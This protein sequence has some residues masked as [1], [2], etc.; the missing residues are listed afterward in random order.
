VAREVHIH[1]YIYLSHW[2]YDILAYIWT[3]NEIRQT[4]TV[5]AYKCCSYCRQQPDAGRSSSCVVSWQVYLGTVCR[6]VYCPSA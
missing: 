6:C 5:A 3:T 2:R 1:V 4:E